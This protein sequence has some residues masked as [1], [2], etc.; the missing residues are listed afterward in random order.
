MCGRRQGR[1]CRADERRGEHYQ[2]EAGSFNFSPDE[3]HVGKPGMLAIQ[4]RN[5]SGLAHNFTLKDPR[6]KILT[7][8]DLVPGDN[9]K[10][11]VELSE[12]GVYP[13]YCDKT[14]HSTFGMNGKIIVGR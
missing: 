8:V 1:D 13:F 12:P 11:S 10:A 2:I 3:I 4:I 6:G 14:F 7:S 9:I 5:I